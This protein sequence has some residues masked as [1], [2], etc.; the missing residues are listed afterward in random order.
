M[1]ESELWLKLAP[2]LTLFENWA[3]SP[4]LTENVNSSTVSP[5]LTFASIFSRTCFELENTVVFKLARQFLD[6][7][8]MYP[9]TL[10]SSL[11]SAI[12]MLYGLK[13]LLW[14]PLNPLWP[15]LSKDG[16]SRRFPTRML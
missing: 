1:V 16:S 2:K 12:S 13:I 14:S 7:S 8:K 6:P 9:L 11:E 10:H 4:S 5:V 15:G 3:F